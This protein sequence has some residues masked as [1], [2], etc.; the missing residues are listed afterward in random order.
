M[1]PFIA[2]L[3]AEIFI[4]P[5]QIFV[6]FNFY[7]QGCFVDNILDGLAARFNRYI[8]SKSYK[9]IPRMKLESTDNDFVFWIQT[10]FELVEIEDVEDQMKAVEKQGRE[11]ASYFW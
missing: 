7:V 2:E 10:E 3:K 9:F 4:R 11:T 8:F 6:P 5:K 1:F